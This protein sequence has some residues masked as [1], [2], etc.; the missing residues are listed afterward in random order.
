[1]GRPISLGN[2]RQS[3]P[4]TLY[5]SLMSSA[6]ERDYVLGTHD[7]ELRRLAFQ[8]DLWRPR[9]REAWLAAGIGAGS[10]VLDV[11]AG[12]GFATLDLAELVGPLGRVVAVERSR[13]FLDHLQVES[14]ARGLAHVDAHEI[15]LMHDAIPTRGLDAAWCRWVACFVN[16]PALLLARVREALRPGGTLVMHEYVDYA[17]Y[18]CLPQRPAIEDFVREVMRSWREH[19]GEPDIARAMPALLPQQGFRIRHAR[20]LGLS[21]MPHEPAWNW[22]AGFV[23]TNVPRMVEL[24]RVTQAWAD[25]VLVELDAAEADPGSLFITPLVLEIVAERA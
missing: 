2:T 21:L 24:G 4:R 5:D 8:H 22:P 23:R 9:V 12:P 14:H 16:D 18:R 3:Q 11:G 20:P 17:A 13:R 15:D 19:G 6:S 10:R 7:A 25:R 1:V